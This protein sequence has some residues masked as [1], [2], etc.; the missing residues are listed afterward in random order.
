VEILPLKIGQLGR[1]EPAIALNIPSMGPHPGSPKV[2]LHHLSPLRDG[3]DMSGVKEVP[4]GEVGL[5]NGDFK[6]NTLGCLAVKTSAIKTSPR[7][8][9]PQVPR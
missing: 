2:N 5:E 6:I 4:A 1:E 3:L 9:P 8:E 7:T